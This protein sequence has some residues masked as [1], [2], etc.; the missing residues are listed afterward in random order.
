MYATFG[1]K[2]DQ[3]YPFL[4]VDPLV[5]L[6]I[7]NEILKEVHDSGQVK[8][9]LTV[10][11][12]DVGLHFKQAQAIYVTPGSQDKW[13]TRKL[14]VLERYNTDAALRPLLRPINQ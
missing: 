3:P 1:D 13:P 6:C 14:R 12:S 5:F 10:E 2:R 9:D 7:I 11:C 8:P 4:L